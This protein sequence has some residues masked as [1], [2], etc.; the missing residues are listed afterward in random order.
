MST[1]HIV[2]IAFKRAEYTFPYKIE[3]PVLPPVLAGLIVTGGRWHSPSRLGSKLLR[4]DMMSK[5]CIYKGDAGKVSLT[6]VQL[7]KMA[8][9][10]IEVA[11]GVQML[12]EFND[13]G[14]MKLAWEFL[15][16]K[17]WAKFMHARFYRNR[18]A[19]AYY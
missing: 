4:S 1:C 13:A 11:I 8:M 5:N 16:K 15:G 6:T 7:R 18:A 14:L 2:Y 3:S 19:A 9:P 17:E 12:K 10:T